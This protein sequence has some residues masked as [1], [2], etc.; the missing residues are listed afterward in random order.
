M[1]LN[2]PAAREIEMVPAPVIDEAANG[3]IPDILEQERG[4][5]DR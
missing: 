5:I 2:Q 1:R 3:I 4:G